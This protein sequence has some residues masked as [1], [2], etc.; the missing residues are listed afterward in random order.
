MT[1]ALNSSSADL[2]DEMGLKNRKA[3]TA[4]KGDV[5]G[6]NLLEKSTD[7]K[8]KESSAYFWSLCLMSAILVGA[9]LGGGRHFKSN[10]YIIETRRVY[11]Q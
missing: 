5:E 1:T 8:I 2:V 11:R 7:K 9:L 3:T 6:A 10:R 4:I